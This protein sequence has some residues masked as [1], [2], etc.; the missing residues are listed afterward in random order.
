M[1]VFIATAGGLTA[2]LQSGA[3]LNEAA[4]S[5]VY[6]VS[7]ADTLSIIVQFK[8]YNISLTTGKRLH[9]AL[10]ILWSLLNKVEVCMLTI[11]Q[12]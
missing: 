6:T 5:V 1:I 4:R 3:K 9:R 2:A 8:Q 11:A 12:N 7:S 10:I